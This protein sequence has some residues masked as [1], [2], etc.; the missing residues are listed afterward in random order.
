MV[1]LAIGES[2]AADAA[3]LSVERSMA[4]LRRGPGA[5]GCKLRC[6]AHPGALFCRRARPGW[7]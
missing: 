4:M 1:W 2:W 6:R 7:I 3:L 5:F